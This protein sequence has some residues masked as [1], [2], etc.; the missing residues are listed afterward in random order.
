MSLLFGPSEPP[1]DKKVEAKQILQA[2]SSSA[3][4]HHFQRAALH[5]ETGSKQHSADF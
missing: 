1:D 5:D 2:I 3:L 4:T